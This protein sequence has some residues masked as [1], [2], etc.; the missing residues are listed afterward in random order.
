MVSTLSTT[1]GKFVGGAI[2]EAIGIQ[3]NNTY[4]Q[5]VGPLSGCT[6]GSPSVGTNVS[7]LTSFTI[8]DDTVNPP[9][10]GQLKIP[11]SGGSAVNQLHLLQQRNQDGALS[12]A[13]AYCLWN[14]HGDQCF[15]RC[16]HHASWH[17]STAWHPAACIQYNPTIEY[18]A[19]VLLAL[20]RCLGRLTV[21]PVPVEVEGTYV[22]KQSNTGLLGIGPVF[23][24][25]MQYKND[26][27]SAVNFCVGE[28]FP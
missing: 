3:I 7:S 17:R 13:D 14:R 1:T 16:V 27:G 21:L 11:T 5:T 4:N 10:A 9:T 20:S 23:Q 2:R 28:G 6:A 15:R 19:L 24:N 25:E 18:L 8:T 26:P 12:G 22:Y